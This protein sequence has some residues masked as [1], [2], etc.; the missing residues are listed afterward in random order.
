MKQVTEV[1]LNLST[2]LNYSFPE[3][4]IILAAGH[5]KR[6]KSQ[7]SKMLHEIYGTT[8]VERVYNACAAAVP[9][10]N[11]VIVVG[12]KA[13]DVMNMIGSKNNNMF[14][15]QAEQKGTGHAVQVALD[16]IKDE[17]YTGIV[18]VLPGDMGLIDKETITGFREKFV[19]SASDMMVLTG[20]FS[21]PVES[22]YYG[23]IV[24][25]KALDA[26]GKP[27]GDDNDKVIEIIEHKDILALNE[28][29]NYV[30]EY[31]GRT[32]TYTKQE[33]L[34]NREYN[35]GVYAFDYKKL[36]TLVHQI[37]SNNVQGEIYITDLIGLF[38]KSGFTVSASSPKE[39]YVVMGFNDKSVLKEMESIYRKNVYNL[40]KNIVEIDDH[41][42]FFI[43]E[44]A[45][46]DIITMDKQG[47]PLDIRIGKGVYIG[48]GVKLN[49]NLHLK[50]NVH[51]SGNVLF[52]KNVVVWDNAELSCYPHQSFV[53]GDNVEILSG[54]IIKGNIVLGE[55]TRIE[56]SVNMTGSDEFPLVIGKNVLVKGTSYIFGSIIEDDIFIEHSVLINKR[57]NK[58]I[59][60]NG[61]VQKIRFYL[62][63]ASG[64][65]AIEHL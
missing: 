22:N 58:L 48:S 60:K 33:M 53:I 30:T 32:Y 51:V 59:K 37:Q 24:R 62:P 26:N 61:E 63:M 19:A 45:I 42:D 10:I 47:A 14:A 31:K 8:T 9:G 64:V 39:E 46:N 57:I 2:E 65:D 29:D 40:L 11:T 49:Y 44:S 35:S 15:Y 43:A 18:Y 50:R 52:G 20:I 36:N 3:T 25:V 23:R 6:I 28:H 13:V 41:E 54:D 55:N 7:R 17:N 21:G 38:N 12:I 5:G 16:E 34:D 1:M 56:S 4:A 27:S